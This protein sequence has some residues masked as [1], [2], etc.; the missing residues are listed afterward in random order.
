MAE[1][2]PQSRRELQ[3]LAGRAR[4]IW[5]ESSKNQQPATVATA[6]RTLCLGRWTMDPCPAPVVRLYKTNQYS[7]TR[8]LE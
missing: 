1:E 8:V 3:N 4:G 6:A 5:Q 2:M 7:S